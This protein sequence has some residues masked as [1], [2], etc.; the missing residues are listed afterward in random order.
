MK[1]QKIIKKITGKLNTYRKIEINEHDEVSVY[2]EALTG[3]ELGL[4]YC[5]FAD[6]HSLF[7]STEDKYVVLTIYPES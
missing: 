2:Y 3:E 6:K 1:P 4:L 7:L 5:L